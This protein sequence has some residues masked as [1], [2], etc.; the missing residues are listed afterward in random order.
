MMVMSPP[1]LPA[2]SPAALYGSVQFDV[3]SR[4]TGRTYRIF[5]FKPDSPPA[6]SGHP[7]VVGTDGNM[8]FPIMATVSATFALTGKAALVVCVGYPTDEPMQLFSLR[9]RDLTPPTPLSG[10]PHR[11]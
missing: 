11:S 10:L 7:V 5:V 8:V 6:P 4:I 2:Q 9:S 3:S 1:D